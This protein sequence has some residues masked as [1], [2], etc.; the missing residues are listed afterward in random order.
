MANEVCNAIE[1]GEPLYLATIDGTDAEKA[2]FVGLGSCETI[3]TAWS[4][5]EEKDG[6]IRTRHLSLS[7]RIEDRVGRQ[8][9][10]RVRIRDWVNG[11]VFFTKT[12]KRNPKTGK[13]RTKTEQKRVIMSWPEVWLRTNPKLNGCRDV[14]VVS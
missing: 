8:W 7:V 6:R 1:N 13:R 5:G 4:H 14:E 12:E 9:M 11:L 2:I 10:P 3:F